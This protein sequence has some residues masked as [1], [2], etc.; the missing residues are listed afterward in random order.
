[1]ARSTPSFR[2]GWREWVLP[3]F[4]AYGV[5]SLAFLPSGVLRKFNHLGDYSYGLYIYAFPV[6]Q[7]LMALYLAAHPHLVVVKGKSPAWEV[8]PYFFSSLLGTLILAFLSWHLVEKPALRT[9]Q[10][11]SRARRTAE[12]L[13]RRW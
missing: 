11:I 1:M 5:L 12:P 4:F 2:W 8:W 13:E 3:V 7:S 9:C 10:R 6:Q